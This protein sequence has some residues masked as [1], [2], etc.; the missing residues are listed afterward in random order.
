MFTKHIMKSILE[1][2]F[3]CL[4]KNCGYDTFLLPLSIFC[5]AVCHVL[6]FF[7]RWFD[8]C[9]DCCSSMPTWIYLSMHRLILFCH[10]LDFFSSFCF[11]L[12]SMDRIVLSIACLGLQNHFN[13]LVWF[14][15]SAIIFSFFFFMCNFKIYIHPSSIHL[16]VDMATS[17]KAYMYV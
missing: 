4:R 15:F 14:F 5:F 17:A 11:I 3:N 16:S 6:F 12:F 8:R 7:S 1:N 10:V 13:F 9:G 2:N